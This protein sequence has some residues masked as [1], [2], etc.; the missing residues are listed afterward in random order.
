MY[1][2]RKVSKQATK[3][4]LARLKYDG[5]AFYSFHFDMGNS[6]SGSLSACARVVARTPEEACLILSESLPEDNR[7]KANEDVNAVEYLEVYFGKITKLMI[8]D[9]E[10][11]TEDDVERYHDDYPVP[12]PLPPSEPNTFQGII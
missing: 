2:K 12:P 4:F 7:V 5:M 1:K 6:S 11:A 10:E 9:V 3:L 8:D